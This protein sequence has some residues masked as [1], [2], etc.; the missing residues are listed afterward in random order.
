MTTQPADSIPGGSMSGAA[1]PLSIGAPTSTLFQR[2]LWF[3]LKFFWAMIFCQG[4][5][6]GILVIGWTYRLVRRSV[7]RFWFSRSS[8]NQSAAEFAAFLTASNFTR[9]HLNWPNWFVHQDF[10]GT[11]AR[12]SEA[13]LHRKVRSFISALSHS[14]WLNFWTGL[15]GILTTWAV[16][17]PAGVL[18]WFG[19]YDGWNNSFNKGYEQAAVGPLISVLG[20]FWFIAVMLYV[21]LGQARQA[22]TGDWRAFFQFRL[23]RRIARENRFSCVALALVY[24]ALAIP[25]NV[26]K[27]TPMFWP[28]M[29]VALAD[30]SPAQAVHALDRY[31]FWCALWVIPA[32]VIGRLIAGRIYA[33]GVLSGVNSGTISVDELSREERDTLLRLGLTELQPRSRRAAWLRFLAWSTTRVGRVVASLVLILLWFVFV[34]QIYISEFISYHGAVGWLNQP[35][36]QLPWF[37]YVPASLKNPVEYVFALVFIGLVALLI[38]SIRRTFAAHGNQPG[39]I[40]QRL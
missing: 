7:L 19:W 4:L 40:Y 13:S 27:S 30:L 6:G 15:S 31:Y 17:L 36:V 2:T 28:Q 32:Y 34:A 35:L 11:L 10:R 5:L 29:N 23:L 25:L 22:V 16:T 9:D 21:P 26:L 24:C 3:P 1:P 18:W 14:L 8:R 39:Q 38:S 33:S 20:I 12:N 37:H